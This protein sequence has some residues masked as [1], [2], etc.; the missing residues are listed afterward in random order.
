MVPQLIPA[1]RF[2]KKKKGEFI[3]Y[4]SIG[5]VRDLPNVFVILDLLLEN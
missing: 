5:K 1:F 2:K 4:I 3:Y